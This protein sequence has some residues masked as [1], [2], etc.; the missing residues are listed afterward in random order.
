M[1]KDCYEIF[2]ERYRAAAPELRSLAKVY[3]LKSHSVVLNSGRE[4]LINFTSRII[5]QITMIDSES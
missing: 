3:W 2:A 5:A 1:P 4:D